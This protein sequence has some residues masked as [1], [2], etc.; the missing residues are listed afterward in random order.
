MKQF[1]ET[2]ET[3]NLDKEPLG[4]AGPEASVSVLDGFAAPPIEEGVGRS[5]GK[6][7]VDGN[8]TLVIVCTLLE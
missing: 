4:S 6:L 5:K 7:F 3:E 2:G 1:S 8:H